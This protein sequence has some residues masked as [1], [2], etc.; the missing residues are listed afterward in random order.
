MNAAD[1]GITL[2]RASAALA[3]SPEKARGTTL[4]LT[5]T[6][7]E[8]L[9]FEVRGPGGEVLHTDMPTALGGEGTAPSPGWLLRAA[10]AACNATVIAMQAARRGIRLTRLEVEAESDTDGRRLLGVDDGAAP[11]SGLR[12]LVRISAQDASEREL[13][14]LVDWAEAHSPVG[15]TLR[16]PPPVTTRVEV[17]A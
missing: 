3:Q 2:E 7:R 11:V 10:L 14:D 6:H 13:R 4:P 9:R 17:L 15:C 12:L 5:A 8:G 16:Q 1:I